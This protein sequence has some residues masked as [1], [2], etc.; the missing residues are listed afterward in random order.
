MECGRGGIL[1]SVELRPRRGRGRG[2]WW[3][4]DSWECQLQHCERVPHGCVP[5]QRAAAPAFAAAPCDAADAALHGA[6]AAAAPAAQ[7]AAAH[8][9]RA[10]AL[11][12]VGAALA[13]A[14]PAAA[15]R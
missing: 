7:P 5:R 4:P 11:A 10:A 6:L 2:P 13:L 9:A 8:A 15:V 14:Q 1:Y 12:A 3:V